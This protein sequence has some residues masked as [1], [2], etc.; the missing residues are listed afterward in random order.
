M[1]PPR[2]F[3]CLNEVAA[4]WSVSGF[5]VIG[6]ATEG[7]IALSAAIPPVMAGTGMIS[8]LVD[9][10]APH[11]LP[12]FRR[13]GTPTQSVTI[14]RVKSGRELHLITEPAD[15]I[16]ITAGDV[17]VRRTEVAR[18]EERHGLFDARPKSDA[19]ETQAI[20][21]APSRAGAPARHDWEGFYGAV[22]RHI[23][24]HGIPKT[25]RELIVGMMT[26]F[27]S[28]GVDHMPD[29]ATV[30]KKVRPVWRELHRA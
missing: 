20:S 13:D 21:R 26:W 18:F 5:D 24:D 10:E 27:E 28:R 22:A 4:R 15:G 12:L 23:H 9:V 16:I 17:L 7:L 25:Q 19:E 30:A 8:G 3:Y 1:L 14:R 6:W 29:E 2:S 11:L